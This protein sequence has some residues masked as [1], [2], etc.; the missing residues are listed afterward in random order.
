VA[1]Q[2]ITRADGILLKVK[3]V[4]RSSR[5]RIG[6][7]YGGGIKVNVT[8]PPEAGAANEA[9]IGM[10]AETLGIGA[11]NIEIVRGHTSPR[12]EILIRG[13]DAKTIAARIS[14]SLGG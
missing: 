9:V 14:A 4:P 5:D 3:V 10:L 2:L 8:K 7:E 6:G 13:M 11:G 12:K 1:L